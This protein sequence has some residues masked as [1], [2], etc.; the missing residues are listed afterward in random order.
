MIVS[1]GF[2][3]LVE[4][5]E[6]HSP[7]PQCDRHP[8]VGESPRS[9]TVTFGRFEFTFGPAHYTSRIVTAGDHPEARPA[10][11]H[12]TSP[13]GNYLEGFDAHVTGESHRKESDRK[14]DLGGRPSGNHLAL[15]GGSEVFSTCT[16]PAALVPS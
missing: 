11:I 4:M 6:L 7:T 8:T 1:A 2:K 3:A 16:P 14:W 13:I 5:K 12:L 9:I 15:G 10:G